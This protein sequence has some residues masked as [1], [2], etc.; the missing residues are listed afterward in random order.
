MTKRAGADRDEAT[1]ILALA[2]VTLMA[3]DLFDALVAS[4]EVPDEAP[5]LAKRLSG[6][7]ML[8]Q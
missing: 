6:L 1:E 4:L 7:P 2:D 3:P 8:N 5:E